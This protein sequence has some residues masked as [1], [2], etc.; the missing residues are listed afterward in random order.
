MLELMTG[1]VKATRFCR[2]DEAFCEG[3]TF[4]QFL[5]L[6]ALAPR[7]SL[8]MSVLHEHL[9]VAKSTTTRLVGPLVKKGLV[10]RLKDPEDARAVRLSLTREGL[11]VHEDV[12]ICI[13]GFL[14]RVFD[15][16][17][18]CKRENTLKAVGTF[19]GAIQ[20]TVRDEKCCVL[21]R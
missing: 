13:S 1:L 16:L 15:N 8:P 12:K 2:Q 3:V 19:I 4:H 6:D 18:A 14:D 10:K 20:K 5:I 7:E 9:A 21:G 17:P 11:H